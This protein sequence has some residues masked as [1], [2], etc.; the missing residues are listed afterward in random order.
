MLSSGIFSC[1][2]KSPRDQNGI[3]QEF[4]PLQISSAP[5]SL[6]ALFGAGRTWHPVSGAAR[7]DHPREVWRSDATTLCG[8]PDIQ[9]EN[10]GEH[11][12]GVVWSKSRLGSSALSMTHAIRSAR[13]YPASGGSVAT[14]H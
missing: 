8:P 12:R 14:A 13:N 3:A 10:P 2:K 9:A 11:R 6:R 1:V 4:I 7:S 5:F